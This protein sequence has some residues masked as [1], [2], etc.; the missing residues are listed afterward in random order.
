MAQEN[1][2]LLRF[3]TEFFPSVQVRD[4]VWPFGCISVLVAGFDFAVCIAD[5]EAAHLV[6][7]VEF[8]TSDPI[9]GEH[10]AGYAC[11][12]FVKLLPE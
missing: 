5:I 8:N 1:C 4:G 7:S 6:G 11:M 12:V 10:A 3:S 2:G 9:P